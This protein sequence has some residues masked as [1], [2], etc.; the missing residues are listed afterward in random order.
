MWEK[1]CHPSFSLPLSIFGQVLLRTEVVSLWPKMFLFFYCREK[2]I[3]DA[4][5]SAEAIGLKGEAEAEAVELLGK[6][7]AEKMS[8]K[9]DAWKDYNRAAKVIYNL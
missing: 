4:S 7:E 1:L 5:A 3:L 9:A 2:L 8:K 6:A